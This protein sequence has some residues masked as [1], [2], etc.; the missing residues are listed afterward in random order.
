MAVLV[1]GIS[2]IVRR[3]ALDSIMSW[4]EFINLVPNLTLCSDHEIARVGFL[5][6]Y[7]T[8]MF[9]QTLELKGLKHL[10]NGQAADISVAD[11]Q[12]GPMSPTPWLDF[13]HIEINGER[14]AAVR[15]KGSTLMKVIM[16]DDW[17]YEGSLSESFSYLSL[18]KE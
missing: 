14:I 1:E 17:E 10:D 4:K 2:V 5:G 6:P 9:I 12:Y 15:L 16:P 8:K 13:G 7:E 18:Q 3:D 11:Q